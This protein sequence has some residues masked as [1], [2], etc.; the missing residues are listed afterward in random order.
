MTDVFEIRRNKLFG[1]ITDKGFIIHH[2]SKKLSLRKDYNDL[3][4]SKN[5]K[6]TNVYTD[7]VSDIRKLNELFINKPSEFM[8]SME[9]LENVMKGID[10]VGFSDVKGIYEFVVKQIALKSEGKLDEFESQ[11]FVRIF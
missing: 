4:L 10:D 6:S 9:V 3:V 1:T 8:L 5:R 11:I 2:E 7:I